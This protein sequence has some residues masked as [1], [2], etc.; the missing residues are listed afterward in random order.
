MLSGFISNLGLSFF[1]STALIIFFSCFVL[2]V[3]QIALS[4]RGE[5]AQE[6]A[7]MPLDD[8]NNSPIAGSNSK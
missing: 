4:V 6:L 5:Q 3:A 1:P 2:I 7:R 8:D